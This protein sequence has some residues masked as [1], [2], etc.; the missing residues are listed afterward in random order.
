MTLF[1]I[2]VLALATAFAAGI[3][4]EKKNAKRINAGLDAAK[5]VT[6]SVVSAAKSV[7]DGVKKL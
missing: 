4:V 2:S 5:S 3:L 6:S 1:I 7:S